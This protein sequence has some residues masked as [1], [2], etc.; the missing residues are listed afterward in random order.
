MTSVLRLFILFFR[1]PFTNCYVWY[2]TVHSGNLSLMQN[3]ILLEIIDWWTTVVCL[4][5]TPPL[6]K[7]WFRVEP[8]QTLVPSTSNPQHWSSLQVLWSLQIQSVGHSAGTGWCVNWI[9]YSEWRSPW[10]ELLEQCGQKA[11]VMEIGPLLSAFAAGMDPPF[12][13]STAIALGGLGLPSIPQ[14]LR[15]WHLRSSP[16][17]LSPS[18]GSWMPSGTMRLFSY[19][20]FVIV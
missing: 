17:P 14:P 7:E 5:H 8:C 19:F 13:S 3:T 15:Q 11:T 1:C 20:F 4:F 18:P 6:S 16:G 9:H 12:T 2:G 10:L